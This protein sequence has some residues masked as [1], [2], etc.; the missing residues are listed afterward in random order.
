MPGVPSY[1][2]L[3]GGPGKHN[4]CKNGSFTNQDRKNKRERLYNNLEEVIKINNS[5]LDYDK[6]WVLKLLINQILNGEL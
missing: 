3:E 6:Y 2:L 1:K 4:N 5:I